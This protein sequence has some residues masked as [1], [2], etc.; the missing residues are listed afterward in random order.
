MEKLELVRIT[1]HINSILFRV[2]YGMYSMRGELKR[3]FPLLCLCGTIR[4]SLGSV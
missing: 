2:E 4:V 1:I 3:K